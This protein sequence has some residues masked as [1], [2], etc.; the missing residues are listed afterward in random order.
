[1]VL[2]GT[3]RYF[4]YY[5]HELLRYSFAVVQSLYIGLMAFNFVLRFS[6][7]LTLL[8]PAELHGIVSRQCSTERAELKADDEAVYV[9]FAY[10]GP[11][12]TVLEIFRRIR[13]L[14]M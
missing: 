9:F 11:V 4:K 6:W 8:Q 14:I 12:I 13:I 7:M 3:Y 10:M 2:S 1:L 5:Y